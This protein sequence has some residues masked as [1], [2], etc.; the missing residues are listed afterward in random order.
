MPSRQRWVYVQP[1][2]PTGSLCLRTV[3]RT[4]EGWNETCIRFQQYSYSSFLRLSYGNK[5]PSYVPPPDYER[6]DSAGVHR[7][8]AAGRSDKSYAWPTQNVRWCSACLSR[9]SRNFCPVNNSS[10]IKHAKSQTRDF[11]PCYWFAREPI[12][13]KCQSKRD[14]DGERITRLDTGEPPAL[15]TRVIC[16]SGID[17][18]RSSVDLTDLTDLA[19]PDCPTL[20]QN[21][22]TVS[23]REKK[24]TLIL[25]MS[26][27]NNSHFKL[28]E[29][30]NNKRSRYICKKKKNVYKTEWLAIPN[31]SLTLNS[32]DWKFFLE[33]KSITNDCF[34]VYFTM[35]YTNPK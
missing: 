27:R 19:W 20:K 30:E 32:N 10:T 26:S 7:A 24:H 17:D 33:S 6:S 11:L 15:E 18:K 2:P 9:R 28:L 12:R 23:Q 25:S 29:S 1:E 22:Q 34:M 31:W 4:A 13:T 16:R 21:Y 8:N 35:Q 3:Q 14:R 5:R